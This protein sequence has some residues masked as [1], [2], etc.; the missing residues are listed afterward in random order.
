MVRWSRT[1]R[2][3]GAT[4][5]SPAPAVEGVGQGALGT[6][7]TD[8]GRYYRLKSAISGGNVCLDVEGKSQS[9]GARVLQWTCSGTGENQ[10]WY[11][12]QISSAPDYQ[13]SAKHSAKCL[14]SDGGS[15][16]SGARMEQDACGHVT[17]QTRLV[18]TRQGT[19]TPPR[20]QIKVMPANKCVRS[21]NTTSGQQVT[22]ET[23]GTGTNF[24]WIFEEQG[25]VA[26]NTGSGTWTAPATV[27]LI[28]AAGA[29][30]PNRKVLVWS[31][32]KP[33]R[34][35]G[36]GSLD[37]TIM[38][39]ID[40]ANP[41]A[42]TGRTITNTTHNMFCPGIAMLPSGDVFV[43]GGDDS[44]TRT[45]SIYRWQTD[46]WTRPASMVESRWYN[47]S[48]TLPDGRVFT[49][50]GN[51]TSGQSGTGEIWNGPAGRSRA[52]PPSA[53][54]PAASPRPAGRWSTRA[55]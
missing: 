43:N 18:L 7:G 41:G 9:N 55:C 33:Y 2:I 30:L 8:T 16:A 21:P 31:S 23:C 19:A 27:P 4:P 34:F 10:R 22:L 47:S 1:R 54:S 14:R 35:A 25:F 29:L 52:G 11:A 13:L 53:T 39:L 48:V 26:E 6:G 40:P 20:Y 44:H 51:R 50:A 17:S 46:D 12:R 3:P 32:W 42:A 49:L 37:Q 5:E 24:Q 36:S 38:A 45:T 28:P 15:S